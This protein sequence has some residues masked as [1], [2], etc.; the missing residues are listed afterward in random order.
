MY[1]IVFRGVGKQNIFDETEDYEKL[2]GILRRVKEETSFELY[3][4]CFMTNHVHLFLREQSVGD[5]AAIMK[6]IL[7]HYATWF[8]RKYDRAG[9]L[10]NN[11]Y[12]SEPVEDEGYI[13]SLIRYIHQNPQKARMV[14]TLAGY[15]YSSYN[16]YANNTPDI[17]DIDFLLEMLSN[18][19]E[20]AISEY[21]EMSA[22]ED[23]E[24]Y[25]IAGRVRKS[26][27]QVRRAIMTELDG[28]EPW[29]IKELDKNKR[30]EILKK[31]VKEI[32]LTKSE[33]ERATGITRYAI[34]KA[35]GEIQQKVIRPH[36]EKEAK[37]SLP[38]HLM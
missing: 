16:E 28:A 36:F 19:R 7:S 14:K 38:A 18:N 17:A 5:I 27:G 4:Y 20:K 13:F 1:H 9:A 35:C 3:A 31:L 15:T 33:L 26:P 29:T 30:D 10:F 11:R 6:K 23:G 12:K 37:K 21:V 34:M 8:N 25:E 22:V 2:K 24:D 32:G